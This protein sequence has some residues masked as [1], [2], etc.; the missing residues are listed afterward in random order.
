MQHRNDWIAKKQITPDMERLLAEQKGQWVR[1]L[2][3]K[4]RELDEISKTL[5]R[6]ASPL[7]QYAV[8]DALC[9]QSR[10]LSGAAH[11]MKSFYDWR[12]PPAPE[13]QD[14]FINQQFLMPRYRR[15]FWLEGAVQCGLGIEQGA[16]I[17]E[18]CCGTGYYAHV[19]YSPFA[20][21]IIAVDYDPRAIE[22]ALRFHR[23]SN[24]RF[25]VADIRKSLP[26]GP[27]D[28]VIWD[29]AIEHFAR[30]EIDDIVERLKQITTPQARL[31]GYTVAEP[32]DAPQLPSHETHFSGIDDL[33]SLLKR[34]YRNVRVFERIHPIA[35]GMMRHNLFFQAS[36]GT[37]PHDPD[38]QHGRRL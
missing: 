16:R 34:H 29:G 23:Q 26:D 13:F 30:A 25:E 19:F 7:D 5:I 33:G 6:A 9:E 10:N 36:D 3:A 24:I 31:L 35:Q 27:F 38:W 21:E 18:L 37:L 14:H 28:A 8:I 15:T 17:L 32:A 4:L 1:F 12:L 20:S 22:T 2:A 11:E